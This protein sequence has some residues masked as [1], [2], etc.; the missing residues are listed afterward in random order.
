MET[1]NEPITLSPQNRIFDA[2]K[3]LAQVID[4]KE[5]TGH[6]ISSS[7]ISEDPINERRSSYV[8]WLICKK[9]H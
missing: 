9:E 1:K 5:N 3:Q 6:V 4:E 8:P 2:V 7:G